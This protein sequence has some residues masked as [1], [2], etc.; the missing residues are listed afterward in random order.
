MLLQGGTLESKQSYLD[1]NVIQD[2]ISLVTF[3]FDSPVSPFFVLLL[4]RVIS[5][6]VHDVDYKNSAKR[7]VM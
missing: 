5:M 7:N 3:S 6:R 1:L 2:F 4:E